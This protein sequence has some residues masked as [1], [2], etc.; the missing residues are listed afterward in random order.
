MSRKVLQ[1]IVFAGATAVSSIALADGGSGFRIVVPMPPPASRPSNADLTAVADAQSIVVIAQKEAADAHAELARAQAE[2][3]RVTRQLQGG[4]EANSDMISAREAVVRAKAAYEAA[5]KPVLAALAQRADYRDACAALTRAQQTSAEVSS[6]V[7]ASFEE[8][9][10]AG[11]AVLNA[12]TAVNRLETVA[13]DNDPE[14]AKAWSQCLA[15]SGRL[16][17]VRARL[18]HTVQWD[19]SWVDASQAVDEA[20]GK[21]LAADRELAAAK[22]DLATA[23]DRVADK[24]AAR[25]QVA[26]WAKSHGLPDPP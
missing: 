14:V 25:Q 6:R 26:D 21:A 10:A 9:V 1:T 22:Q 23:R 20:Q 3:K 2:L 7:V 15:A 12:K 4:L 8:R 24:Q 13:L 19:P 17:E 11:Q 16:R 18:E 5:T